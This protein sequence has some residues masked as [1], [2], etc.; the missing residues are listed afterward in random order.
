MKRH[1]PD[2][3]ILLVA[4]TLAGI[5]V[6][7]VFSSSSVMA[8]LRYNNPYYYLQRQA[9]WMA[10]GTLAMVATMNFDYRR[11]RS[12][13]KAGF[14]I[15]LLLLALVLIPG[16]G[17]ARLGARRWIGFGPMQFQPSELMKI[18][19]V[20]YL[21]YT[22][23]KDRAKLRDFWRDLMPRLVLLG[24]VFGLI[25]LEP[26]MGTSLATA[27]TVVV[28]LFAAG[29][30]LGHLMTLAAAAVPM[31]L[32][33]IW[34]A[35]YRLRRFLSFL[36]P[37]A[38]PQ[39]SGYH[40]IQALYAFGS[41]GLFGVG[42]GAGKLKFGYLP[43]NHTDSIFAMIGEELGFLGAVVV[44]ILFFLLAWRGLQVATHAPDAF[45]SLLAVGLTATVVVQAFLNI[46]VISASIPFTGIPLPL[47]SYGGTNLLITMAGVGILLNVSRYTTH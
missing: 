1:A 21:A 8:G 25:M 22:L 29:A 37:K 43:E 13:A 20:V 28:M 6:V 38:D 44:I 27:G 31:L 39:G 15:N 24:L 42:L 46:A 33:L 10:L 40:V 16:I 35:P 19:F 34:V 45:G 4:L 7:M 23:S 5:G 11:Y 12:V 18:A 2:Y 3:V 32:G 17:M 47:V 41:G 36:D 9:L 30:R 14:F 26:D